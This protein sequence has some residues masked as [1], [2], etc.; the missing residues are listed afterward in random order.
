[1]E[2]AGRIFD[3]ICDKGLKIIVLGIFS[4]LAYW[5]LRYTYFYPA[6]Y[7]SE[8]V[9]I[10]PDSMAK[11][12]IAFF[13]VVIITYIL[14]R[15]L[16]VGDEKNKQKRVFCFVIIDLILLGI[17]MIW[18]VSNTHI[19]PYWDQA[20][21]YLDALSFKSGDY[22]DINGY[23][24]MYPQQYGLIFLYE[25][26]FLFAP[27][28]YI[29]I[30]Y[31]NVLFVL[32]L[33]YFSYKITDE[34]FHNAA[35]SFY[36]VL[37]MTFFLPL[38]LYVNFVYGD[39]GSTALAVGGMYGFVK[40]CEKG[41]K[42]YAVLSVICFCIAYMLRKNILIVLIAVLLA[43]LVETFRKLDWRPI[44]VGILVMVLPLVGMGCVTKSY[45]FRSGKE[46]EGGIPSIMWVAMGLQG[47]YNEYYNE[48]GMF[49]GYTESTYRGI[50]QSDSEYT[51]EIGKAYINERILEFKNNPQMAKDFFKAKIQLQWTEPTYSSLIMTSKFGESLTE[52][53]SR[54]YFGTIP[55]KM[56][57]LMDRYSFI[58]YASV[59]IGMMISLFRR[60]RVYKNVILIAVV[61]GFLFS[62]IWE[63]KGRYVM[64]Y[65][66]FLV[67][68]MS[69]G[70]FEVQ[71]LFVKHINRFKK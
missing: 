11:N 10:A 23:L 39:V 64:P 15:F 50:G 46:I 25:F 22:S 40:W 52:V 27:D 58:L 54:V 34:M 18:Y 17:F 53:T 59:A 42:R 60:D 62:I 26:L 67:P 33:I 8:I 69:R 61:G 35:V 4:V 48:C 6:D 3:F 51:A 12:S 37:G 7:S 29:T 28:E 65:V 32:L 56:I 21:V 20:Q 57:Q 44:L 71:S 14:Q 68:Y 24:N 43:A 1:M 66:V 38:H 13:V 30:Q 19:P 63:A 31:A 2:K 5:A 41:L 49:N 9:S 47:D 45:E 55:E 16:L 70:I 36:C